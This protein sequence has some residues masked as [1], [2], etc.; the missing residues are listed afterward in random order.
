LTHLVDRFLFHLVVIMPLVAGIALGLLG[1]GMVEASRCR[2][3][4]VAAAGGLLAGCVLF[5]GT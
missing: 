3:R 2:N 5:F 1:D 4:W